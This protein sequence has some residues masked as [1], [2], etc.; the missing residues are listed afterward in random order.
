MH[1]FPSKIGKSTTSPSL[2]QLAL[3]PVEEITDKCRPEL[4]HLTRRK[5]SI[6][7]KCIR[8]NKLQLGVWLVTS[9]PWRYNFPLIWV[10]VITS[11]LSCLN[12]G[13]TVR[14][15]KFS[16]SKGK[17]SSS[18]I[19][20]HNS[21][22]VWAKSAPVAVSHSGWITFDHSCNLYQKKYR[23]P[24]GNESRTVVITLQQNNRKAIAINNHNGRVFYTTF[25]WRHLFLLLLYSN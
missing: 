2:S 14:A 20:T 5:K 7:T 1:G 16:S 18:A 13:W 12:V 9:V 22:R 23:R 10:H 21:N 19:L 15:N 8:W 17:T 24:D 6:D 25:V 3:F 11:G 4:N